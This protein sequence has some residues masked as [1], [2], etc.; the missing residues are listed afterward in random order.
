MATSARPGPFA[1]ST[2]ID[3]EP[4][5]A[6]IMNTF[7]LALQQHGIAIAEEAVLLPNGVLVQ[8]HECARSPAKALTSIISV[9]LGRWKLVIS[10]STT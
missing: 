1:S 10:K 5:A 2:A 8:R 3:I 6:A 7:L 4:G 9:L